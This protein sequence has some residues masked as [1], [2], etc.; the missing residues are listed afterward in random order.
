MST[1][2]ISFY[3][4]IY[5]YLSISIH[6][7]I[8]P[9]IHLSI[10]QINSNLTY[11]GLIQSNLSTYLSI[12]LSICLSVHLSICL[13]V[14]LSIC[15]SIYRYIISIFLSTHYRVCIFHTDID[16]YTVYYI[17]MYSTC[18]SLMYHIIF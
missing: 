15:L 1:V 11:P 14:Y 9:H 2:S 18:I 6:P 5:H 17:Y 16:I 10:H 3:I 12:C 7:S 4:Y 13:S 8:Y